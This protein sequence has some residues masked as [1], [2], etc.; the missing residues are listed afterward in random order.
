MMMRRPGPSVT[1]AAIR[2]LTTWR[3]RRTASCVSDCDREMSVPYRTECTSINFITFRVY[4]TVTHDRSGT[5]RQSPTKPVGPFRTPVDPRF[6]DLKG[7]GCFAMASFDKEVLEQ[8]FSRLSESQLSVQTLSLWI[9]HHSRHAEAV[10]QL[11]FQHV[12]DGG[13][14]G[15]SLCKSTLEISG[16]LIMLLKMTLFGHSPCK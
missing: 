9:L 2:M 3:R 11:W 16:I 10:C 14:N 15:V 4:L 7:N 6:T 8:R 5:G 13:W 12:L 1:G